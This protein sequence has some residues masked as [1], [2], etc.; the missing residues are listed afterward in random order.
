MSLSFGF[1]SYF[2]MTRFRP[3]I[4]CRNLTEVILAS[5]HW[6]SW[7]R[8]SRLVPLLVKFTLITCLRSCLPGFFTAKLLFFPFGINKHFMIWCFKTLCSLVPLSVYPYIYLYQCGLL[9]LSFFLYE[10]RTYCIFLNFYLFFKI[11]YFIQSVLIHSKYLFEAQNVP[12]VA[13]S[14]PFKWAA[15]SFWHVPPALSTCFLTSTRCPKLPFNYP[16]TAL[17]Q[18]FL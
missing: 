9:F 17:N 10:S 5:S 4:H 12:D 18:P 13:S 15:V 3:Y 1:V 7:Q 8:C 14:N 11:S 2:P 16:G 6:P